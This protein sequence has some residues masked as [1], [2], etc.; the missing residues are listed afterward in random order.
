MP[1]KVNTFNATTRSEWRKW[2]RKNHRSEKFVWL[3]KH[4]VHTGKPT[5]SHRESMEEAICYGWIDTI[6]KRLDSDRY[7]RGFAKRNS[8]SR[9][10]SATRSYAN[11]LIKKRKMTKAGMQAYLSGLK[12]PTIDMGLPQDAKII[13]DDLREELG[14]SDALAN[15][16]KL[17]PSYRRYYLRWLARAKRQETRQKRLKIIIENSLKSKKPGI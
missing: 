10:S 8:N 4:K 13:P 9:W 14:K 11:D 2:L 15:F 6:V 7:M 1:S 16:E 3:V 5:L 17:A 12:K